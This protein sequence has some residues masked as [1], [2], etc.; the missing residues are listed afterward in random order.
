M[1]VFL[2]LCKKE[3]LEAEKPF[4][5]S[6]NVRI[7]RELHEKAIITALAK[8]ISLNEFVKVAL[9]HELENY[10]EQSNFSVD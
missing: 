1:A 9:N 6:F 4:K 2:L 7:G 5:G 8:D 10:A 3:N